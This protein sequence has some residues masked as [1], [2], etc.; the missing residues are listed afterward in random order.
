MDK[1]NMSSGAE[2]NGAEP[3]VVDV[4]P[5]KRPQP[6][7]TKKRCVCYCVVCENA[8]FQA[9]GTA[10][11]FVPDSLGVV[12]LPLSLLQSVCEEAKGR[13]Q[14]AGHHLVLLQPFV[15]WHGGDQRGWQEGR[16]ER[17]EDAENARRRQN[18]PGQT[19]A[20][21]RAADR[22]GDASCMLFRVSE[23]STLLTLHFVDRENEAIARQVA[24]PAPHSGGEQVP[25][26]GQSVVPGREKGPS[27]ADSCSRASGARRRPSAVRRHL[28]GVEFPAPIQ[29][30]LLN[31]ATDRT[32][33]VCIAE[34]FVVGVVVVLQQLALSAAL[35]C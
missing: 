20:Q 17:V 29:V 24:A 34:C 22:G 4:T 26:R 28:H 6:S 14:K 5:K 16:S 13:Q 33:G 25:D 35:R 31:V 27:S 1:E 18:D 7:A 2:Q 12:L 9:V 15:Q 30:R 19:E 23:R 32:S 11:G 8:R 3:E 10:L 21:D